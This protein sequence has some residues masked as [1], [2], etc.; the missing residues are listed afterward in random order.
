[1]KHR[2]IA[3]SHLSG[4][5]PFTE[6]VRAMQ[7][8]WNAGHGFGVSADAITPAPEGMIECR[9]SGS[10]GPMPKVIRRSF[11]SWRNSIAVN[12]RLFDY[13]NTD[14]FAVLG[15]LS[16]SLTAYAVIEAAHMR[17]GL[18]IGAG[19]G[20]QALR[21]ALGTATILH[22]TPTQLR[23][24]IPLGPFN[25]LR[26][27]LVGGGALDT[28]TRAALSE[29]APNAHVVTYFGASEASFI[30]L[31]DGTAPVGSVGRAYPEVQIE[32][33]DPENGI[34]EIW[35]RSPYLF[36]GYAAGTDPDV[37]LSDGWL[38]IGEMGH[39]DSNGLLYVAGRKNRMF[40]SSDINIFPE[41][42]E[43]WCEKQGATA[44]AA[45]PKPDPKRGAVPICFY[46]G[47]PAPDVITAAAQAELPVPPKRFIQ[48]T[49]WPVLPAGKTDLATLA[50]H[51][52]MT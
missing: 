26:L 24:V 21:S 46:T 12:R 19:L 41:A 42:I 4:P 11:D 38:T 17:A 27:I 9:T 43:K 52:A 31:D 16:H 51:E 36:D 29:V 32:V 33:R 23:G 18:V 49:D 6:Q 45:L 44:A 48:L 10:T 30:A 20:R 13:S 22:V 3:L 28:A 47:G 7:A 1:M 8:A 5:A 50:R 34:G 39:M 14:V 25:G 15:A 35:L 2:D 37:R 40:T